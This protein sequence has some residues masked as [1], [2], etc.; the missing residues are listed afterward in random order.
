MKTAVKIE[1]TILE[2]KPVEIVKTQIRI[3]GTTPLIIHNFGEKSR[4]E[5][6]EK[7][8]KITKTKGHDAKNPVEDFMNSLYWLTEKPKAATEDA[9]KQAA[10]M[11]ASRNDI[12]VKTTTLRGMFFL[13][14]LGAGGSEF[15]EISGSVPRMREDVVRIGGISKTADLRYRAEFDPWYI[16]LMIEFNKNGPVTIEQILNRRRTVPSA[17]T[18]LPFSKHG[19]Q[20][21]ARLGA[22]RCGMVW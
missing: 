21:P 9:F 2:I 14:G 13:K 15:A 4:R 12:D 18:G 7:Q 6:L 16:D 11:A 20:G 17:C 22:V 8:M 5:M 3:E 10:I 1:Q 19:R